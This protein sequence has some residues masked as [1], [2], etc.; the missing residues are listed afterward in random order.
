MISGKPEENVKDIVKKIINLKMPKNCSNVTGI[1]IEAVEC[2]IINL[3][4]K[5]VN[6]K[7]MLKQFLYIFLIWFCL[8][9]IIAV[10]LWCSKGETTIDE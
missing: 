2:L 10:P 3:Q 9:L 1:G 6:K 8:Y 4:N 5:T 7:T